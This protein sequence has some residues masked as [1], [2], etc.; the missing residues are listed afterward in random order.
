M[1]QVAD[2]APALCISNNDA[3]NVKAPYLARKQEM[4]NAG[5]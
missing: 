5:S 1:L 4:V 3:D 2:V